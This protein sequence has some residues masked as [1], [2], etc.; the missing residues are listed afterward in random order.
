LRHCHAYL[1]LCATHASR[2]KAGGGAT[3]LVPNSLQTCKH[4]TSAI[5]IVNSL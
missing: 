5:K 4:P 1:L 3:Y 2:H